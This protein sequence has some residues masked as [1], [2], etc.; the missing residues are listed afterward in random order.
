MGKHGAIPLRSWVVR[1]EPYMGDVSQ[2]RGWL[3]MS[4]LQYSAYTMGIIMG[5]WG[6]GNVV[7]VCENVP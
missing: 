5:E 3:V 4:D 7:C 6:L 2:E 1:D